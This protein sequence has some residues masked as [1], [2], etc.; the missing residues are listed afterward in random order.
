MGGLRPG[1]R[2]VEQQRKC[3]GTK[4]G[5]RFRESFIP[6]V[7]GLPQSASAACRQEL[8]TERDADD[9]EEVGDRA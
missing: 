6:V 4:G 5:V 9:G 2:Y 7:Q 8:K 1:M 3:S